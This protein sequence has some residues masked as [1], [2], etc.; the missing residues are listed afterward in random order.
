MHTP[1][2]LMRL[3]GYRSDD[4]LHARRRGLDM[5]TVYEVVLGGRKVSKRAVGRGNLLG[6]E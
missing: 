1:S 5:Y 3:R 4:H 2:Y 6:L